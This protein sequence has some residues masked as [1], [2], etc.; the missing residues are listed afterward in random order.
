MASWVI[1][2][3][4]APPSALTRTLLLRL[5]RDGSVGLQE[6]AA[7]AL[8]APLPLKHGRLGWASICVPVKVAQSRRAL[9]ERTGPALCAVNG[10]EAELRAGGPGE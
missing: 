8:L 7:A 5:G 3:M 4:G 9:Q 10:G 6:R 2:P 1:S